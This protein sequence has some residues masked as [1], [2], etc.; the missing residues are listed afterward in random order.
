MRVAEILEQ[1]HVETTAINEHG[2]VDAKETSECVF[3]CDQAEYLELIVK[4]NSFILGHFR[5]INR[6]SIALLGE[7]PVKFEIKLF[8][9]SIC[10]QESA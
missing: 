5:S 9:E 2:K 4:V 3:D 10:Q 8:N 7:V 1:E 6:K